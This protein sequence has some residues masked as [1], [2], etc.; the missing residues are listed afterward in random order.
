[1]DKSFK[2]YSNEN[3]GGLMENKDKVEITVGGSIGYKIISKPY[4]SIDSNSFGSIKKEVEE[5][6]MEEEM[7]ILSEELDLI[8]K[9]DVIRRLKMAADTYKNEVEKVRKIYEKG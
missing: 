2:F 8:L 6:K 7:K 1:M 4:E 3:Q 9:R 5:D